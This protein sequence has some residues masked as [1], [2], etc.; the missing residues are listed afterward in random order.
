MTLAQVRKVGTEVL[1]GLGAIHARGMIHR[2][3]K[4][5]NILLNRR[6]EAQISDFGLVTDEL[7]LGYAGQAGYSD[8]IAYEVWNNVGTSAKSDIWALGM[9]LYRLLHGKVWYESAPRPRDIVRLGGLANTLKW[10]PHIPKPWRRVVRKMLN[11]DPGARYQNAGQA[12]GGLARLPVTPTWLPTVTPAL[13]RWEQLKGARRVVVEWRRHAQ[14][15]HEWRA[16]REPVGAGRDKQLSASTGT[17][18]GSQIVRELEDF[19]AI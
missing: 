15:K 6:S 2:D 17:I 1:M 7:V 10:L 3:I 8:H 11:D 18:G 14:R 5:A 13:V 16:W 12:L 19:F 4:P 9:T